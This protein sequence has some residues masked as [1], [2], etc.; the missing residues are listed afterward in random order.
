VIKMP[1]KN[2]SELPASVKD[3]LPKKAQAIFM[4]AFNASYSKYGEE[5]A[6]KIAWAAVKHKFKKVKDKWVSKYVVPQEYAY[7]RYVFESDSESVSKAEDGSVY[8]D[9][10]LSSNSVDKHGQ[11]FSD[12]ALKRIVEQINSEGVTGRLEKKHELWKKLAEEGKSEE[13][14]EKILQSQDTGIKAISAKFENGKVIARIKM[15]PEAYKLAKDVSGASIEARMPA[16][17]Y[18]AGVFHQARLQGFVLTDEP[19]NPDAVVV[20]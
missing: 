6:F 8:R 7:V 20:S 2:T 1:Y 11:S 9:Y 4:G 13:E 19:A 5:R 3:N 14:I 12:F 17:S 10:V 18:R 15:T 16:E